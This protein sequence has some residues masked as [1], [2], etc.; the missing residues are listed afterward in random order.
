LKDF[1]SNNFYL[2]G[3]YEFP[4]TYALPWVLPGSYKEEKGKWKAKIVY[5][6]KAILVSPKGNK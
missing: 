6:M 1:H 4:G 2:H 3:Q 5:Q